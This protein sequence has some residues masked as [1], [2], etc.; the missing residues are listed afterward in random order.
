MA[1]NDLRIKNRFNVFYALLAVCIIFV[2]PYKKIT[3]EVILVIVAV[4][5]IGCFFEKSDYDRMKEAEK[6]P[7]FTKEEAERYYYNELKSKQK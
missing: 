3:M 4:Y 7:P 5:I 2:L 6:L 1:H